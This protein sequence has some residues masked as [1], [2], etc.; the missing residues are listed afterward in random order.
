MSTVSTLVLD[1]KVSDQSWWGGICALTELH[2][3]CSLLGRPTYVSSRAALVFAA[4][5]F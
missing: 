3:S 2:S 1:F 4:V 5:L